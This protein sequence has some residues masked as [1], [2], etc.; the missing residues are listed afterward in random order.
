MGDIAIWPRALT[1]QEVISWQNREL[2]GDFGS[3]E[4]SQLL[5]FN[6]HDMRGI[7][8]FFYQCV[9]HQ[10]LTFQC[11]TSWNSQNHHS[12]FP[13]FAARPVGLS[14]GLITDLM[15]YAS[16]TLAGY[17]PTAGRAGHTLTPTGS[18]AEGGAWCAATHGAF[19][20]IELE[21]Q[22]VITHLTVQV[23]CYLQPSKA[24]QQNKLRYLVD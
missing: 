23:K 22:Y 9:T 6:V 19:W 24:T 11:S 15:A 10:F 3:T 1:A 21:Q 4:T 2:Q 20:T 12:L 13:F 5:F 17:P 18:G 14:N 8:H 16:S 7:C